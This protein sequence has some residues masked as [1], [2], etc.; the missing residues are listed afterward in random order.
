MEK[1]NNPKVFISYAW[2]SE[3][4]QRKV[5]NFASQ[6]KSDGI[7]VLLDVWS[8]VGGND[9]YDFMERSVKDETVTNVLILINDQY[10]KK[11][12]NR[13]GGVGTEAEII[14]PKLYTAA[15]QSK[16]I[17]IIFERNADGKIHIPVF[18]ESR[19][20]FD[21]SR[22]DK[23]DDEYKMMVRHLY[24]RAY[25]R[26]PEKGPTPKWVDEEFEITPKKHAAYDSL[27]ENDSPKIKA[28]KFSGYLTEITDEMV[29]YAKSYS[30]IKE[31]EKYLAA[32]EESTR[33]RTE[34][35]NIISNY[36]YIDNGASLIGDFLED[37]FNKVDSVNQFGREFG[38]ARLFE[39]F[40]Y[41]MAVFLKKKD[42]HS[43]AYLLGRTYFVTRY[44]PKA[45]SY[46]MFFR[47]GHQT[48]LDYSVSNRDGKE[49]Y[50]G[51]AQYW[52]ENIDT[53]FCSKMDFLAADQ[54]CANYS[55]YGNDYIGE[56]AWFPITYI[57]D[58]EDDSITSNWA[59]R[60]SSREK[61]DQMLTL[62]NYDSVE[63]FKKKFTEADERIYNGDL[64]HFGYS[65]A[66][67]NVPLFGKYI[68]ASEIGTQR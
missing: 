45:R 6:L 16:F 55:V 29:E 27:K 53:N 63:Q 39:M 37:T 56:H 60:L 7:E 18:L 57:Y 36:Q 13:D 41:T 38:M 32:Y 68:K 54:I 47:G 23:Y 5:I 58:K 12:D 43:A 10:G 11:A 24:G 52:M 1:I 35:L 28:G 48:N 64:H 61:L 20:Y 22:E 33:F 62:M 49:Y 4:Y 44:E 42:F 50:C 26:E 9:L 15:Q 67:R 19:K 21:L 31:P 14:S 34:Y 59:V 25:Y 65:A 17:P 3:N 66:F 46:D 30:Y 40:L 51:T 8:T 2:T